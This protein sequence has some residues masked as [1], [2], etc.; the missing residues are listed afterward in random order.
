MRTD[1]I[2]AEGLNP[3]PVFTAAFGIRPGDV[4]SLVGC[5]GKTSLQNRLAAENR[6]RTVLLT[7]TTKIRPPA[8][9]TVDHRPQIP[10]DL[11][12]GV[13]LVFGREAEGKLTGLTPGQLAAWLPGAEIT[14]IEADGSKGLPLKGWAAHEPVVPAATTITIGVCTVRPVGGRCNAGLVHRP[15]EFRRLTG[16]A[17]GEPVTVAHIAA[18]AGRSTGMFARAAGRRLLMI[19]QVERPQDAELARLLALQLRPYDPEGWLECFMG[20]IQNGTVEKIER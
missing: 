6:D 13:N 10:A 2:K 1:D 20:S 7:T 19:N 9:D 5:G 18:M 12:R 14:L 16:A 15:E 11:R 3:P 4:V 8:G 17:P